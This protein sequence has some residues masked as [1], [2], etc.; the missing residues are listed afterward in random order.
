MAI[1]RSY[2]GLVPW[3]GMRDNKSCVQ[4]QLTGLNAKAHFK[5]IEQRHHD[6]VQA[7]LSP[8]GTIQWRLLPG[9]KESQINVE[10]A[11]TPSKPETWPELN[12][13]M[14]RTLEMMHAL[15]SPIVKSLDAAEY[16]EPVEES[17]EVEVIT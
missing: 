5:L 9:K 1:G 7:R 4:L 15:F 11:A 8:L 6:E 12:E 16:E 17:P 13:W 2:F 3:S 14:A 10:R